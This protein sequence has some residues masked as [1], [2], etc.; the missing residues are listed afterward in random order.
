MSI[1]SLLLIPYYYYGREGA[2]FKDSLKAC[3]LVTVVL[4]LA[5]ALV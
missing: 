4:L 3:S 5:F 2:L 1:L